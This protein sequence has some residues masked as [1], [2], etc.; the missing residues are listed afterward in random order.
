M[1][2]I[3]VDL[4]IAENFASVKDMQESMYTDDELI[5][6]YLQWKWSKFPEEHLKDVNQLLSNSLNKEAQH[7]S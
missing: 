7:G 3:Y 2:S 6:K 5:Q 1:S 4:F